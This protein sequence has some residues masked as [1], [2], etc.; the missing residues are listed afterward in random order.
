MDNGFVYING[1]P[2]PYP[3]R[4]SGLQT[5]VTLVDNARAAD[6]SMRGEKIG[7]DQSKVE[8]MWSALTPEQWS[9]M[10][11]EFDKFEFTIRYIDMVTNDWITRTFYV[12]DRSAKPY[13]ID[14]ITNRP[15]W[16]LNCKANV[17][18]TGK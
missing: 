14:P 5:V 16:Y 17:I 6:G 10:L 1:K 8:L 4:D 2:F 13:L 18:D 12:G 3:S 7:R 11:Q 15:K 9:E